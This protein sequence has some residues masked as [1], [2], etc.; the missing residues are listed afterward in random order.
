M[1]QYAN[2]YCGYSKEI[3]V[4]NLK[5]DFHSTTGFHIKVSNVISLLHVNNMHLS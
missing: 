1:L 4:K 5:P 2:I 3:N